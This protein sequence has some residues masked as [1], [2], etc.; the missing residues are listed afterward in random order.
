MKLGEGVEW[1]LHCCT[2]LGAI[3]AELTVPSS[4]LAEFHGV[5]PTYLAKQMQALA[6][7]GIVDSIPGRT[8]GYKLARSASDITVLD[9]VL[10]AEGAE[11]AF[12]CTEIRQQGPSASSPSSYVKACGIAATMWRAEEMYRQEL[13][14]TTIGDLVAE[15]D[16]E[17][18]DEQTEKAISWLS[19]QLGLPQRAITAG[20]SV[21]IERQP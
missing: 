6:R 5:R 15:L 17:V 1:A 19:E 10:A 7:A 13:A 12:R 16:S 20:T 2:V 8:G 14:A 3:P 9:V 4:V 21:H 11:R 18:D